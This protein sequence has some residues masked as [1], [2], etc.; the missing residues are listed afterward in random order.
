MTQ[1]IQ[2]Q[3]SVL[4]VHTQ[5]GLAESLI[6]R[7]KLIVRPLQ[8]N[9]NLPISCWDYAILHT[10]DLIQL[11]PTAYHTTSPLYLVRDNTPNIFHVRKFGCA[12]YA[13]ISPSKRTSMPPTPHRKLGIYVVYH[14]PSI[15]NYLEPLTENL[16]TTRYV[17]CIFN[18]DHFPKLWG[19]Y[20]YHSKCQEINLDDKSIISSDP[21]TKEIELQVQKIINL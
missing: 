4:Y 8:H 14:F 9:C 19:D 11:R 17:D 10:T 21:C 13:P 15:I 5:N 12:V 20:K 2:V 6:K 3:H 18:V 7:I 1:G 16:F